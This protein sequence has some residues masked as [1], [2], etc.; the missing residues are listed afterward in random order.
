MPAVEIRN[1][2]CLSREDKTCFG[3]GNIQGSC[4][5]VRTQEFELWRVRRTYSELSG[6]GSPNS[7]FC[8]EQWGYEHDKSDKEEY[9]AFQSLL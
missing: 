3:R 6:V 5:Y 1:S 4:R 9:S 7:V 2:F 8:W